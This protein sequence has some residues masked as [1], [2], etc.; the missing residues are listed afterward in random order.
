MN[1]SPEI[2][3]P[4]VVS[5]LDRFIETDAHIF[6]AEKREKLP[7]FLR[8]MH[9]KQGKRFLSK[10]PVFRSATETVHNQMILEARYYLLLNPEVKLLDLSNRE[11]VEFSM[12]F[13]PPYV[14]FEP[15]LLSR[16]AE[17]LNSESPISTAALRV[18]EHKSELLFRE[19]RHLNLADFI[20]VRKKP[21]VTPLLKALA[22]MSHCDY[23]TQ[24]YLDQLPK[25]R[26]GLSN[27]ENTQLSRSA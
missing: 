19:N 27:L 14:K 9:G 3:Q 21:P 7:T 11:K 16:I 18:A 24:R 10:L 12:N 8:H 26:L 22:H 13:Q 4:H 25:L 6:I 23:C 1:S 20:D 17:K 15:G 2:W 5:A